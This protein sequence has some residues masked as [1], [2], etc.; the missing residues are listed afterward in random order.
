MYSAENNVWTSL[1]IASINGHVN[2]I[3]L[4]NHG[5][6]V[7]ITGNDVTIPLRA[8]A[9]NGQLEVNGQLQSNGCSVHIARTRDFTALLAA[10]DSG[11]VEVLCELLK[12]RACVVIAIKKCSELLKVAAERNHVDVR[13]AEIWC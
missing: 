2:F 8:V 12:Q 1:K 3:L 4:L 7:G 6:S 9:C 5:L 13:V 10:A 11:S